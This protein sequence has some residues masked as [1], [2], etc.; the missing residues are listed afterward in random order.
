MTV[1]LVRVYSNC[2]AG[3]ELRF[4]STELVSYVAILANYIVSDL[5]LLLFT[6]Y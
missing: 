4:L 1:P 3:T 6:G 2:W 5:L